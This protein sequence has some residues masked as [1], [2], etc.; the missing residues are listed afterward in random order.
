MLLSYIYFFLFLPFVPR[1]LAILNSIPLLYF[2]DTKSRTQRVTSFL[3]EHRRSLFKIKLGKQYIIE[4]SLT[5]I[6]VSKAFESLVHAILLAKLDYRYNWASAG[7]N[8]KLLT[9]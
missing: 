1:I 8:T 3:K 9:L 5:H 6:D 7:V 2:V 4:I